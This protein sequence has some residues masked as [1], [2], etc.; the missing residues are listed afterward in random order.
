ME[1]MD[2]RKQRLEKIQ[3]WLNDAAYECRDILDKWQDVAEE[4]EDKSAAYGRLAHL[5]EY[6]VALL[7]DARRYGAGIKDVETGRHLCRYIIEQNQQ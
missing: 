7:Y 2:K 5:Q 4:S 6:A 3:R 1:F